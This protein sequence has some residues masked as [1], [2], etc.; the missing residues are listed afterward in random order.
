MNARNKYQILMY[1]CYFC[2]L[3]QECEYIIPKVLWFP[4]KITTNT[5]KNMPSNF[6]SKFNDEQ[7]EILANTC[8]SYYVDCHEIV[9]QPQLIHYFLMREVKQPNTKEIWFKVVV[10]Y[11][12][13]SLLEFYLVMGLR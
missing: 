10:R 2:H 3:L 4:D 9:F 11:I 7:K 8:F 5:T 6:T 1:V 13:F 12:Q